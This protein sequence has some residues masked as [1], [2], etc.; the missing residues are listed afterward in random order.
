MHHV[1]RECVSH[2]AVR[3]GDHIAISPLINRR[4]QRRIDCAV[5]Y[6]L[7]NCNYLATFECVSALCR[8][9]KKYLLELKNILLIM[10]DGPPMN[11]NIRSTPLYLSIWVFGAMFAGLYELL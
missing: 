11:R 8:K 7:L 6:H 10:R 2:L 3:S 1:N 9:N 4:K 5:C